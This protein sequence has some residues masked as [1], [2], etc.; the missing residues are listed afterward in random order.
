MDAVD[1]LHHEN[2]STCPGTNP[3]ATRQGQLLRCPAG[4][5]YYQGRSCRRISRINDTGAP[6][7]P[8]N[9][10]PTSKKFPPQSLLR[11]I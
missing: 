7:G 1:F 4:Y 5:Y 9:R 3:Q 2:P 8:T 10:A 6:T 11:Q